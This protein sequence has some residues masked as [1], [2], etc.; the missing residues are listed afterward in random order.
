MGP[1]LTRYMTI[2]TCPCCGRK[3]DLVGWLT[4]PLIGQ[5]DYGDGPLQMRNCPCSNA[6]LCLPLSE[7]K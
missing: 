3:Y 7:V 6:T 4:L 1:A 2:K 5:T